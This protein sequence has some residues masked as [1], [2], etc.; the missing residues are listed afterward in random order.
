MI[1]KNIFEVPLESV[2]AHEGQGYIQFKRMLHTEEFE[3]SWHFVDYAVI[4]SGCSIGE[5][6]HGRNEE[7]Y[8]ILEGRAI[9][10]INNQEYEVK[11]GDLVL[12]RSGWKHGLRNENSSEVRILVVE[13]G[14]SEE[15]HA[16]EKA[17]G[18]D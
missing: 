16:S 14:I 13:V 8:F 4:P 1:R 6:R 9:M 7:L 2:I 10:R 5:H 3:G 15:K 18:T 12:N 17:T 11:P